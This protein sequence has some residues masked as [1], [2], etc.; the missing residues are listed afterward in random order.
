[1]LIEGEFYFTG[2]ITKTNNIIKK[3]GNAEIQIW[4]L[5]RGFGPKKLPLPKCGIN[6]RISIS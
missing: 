5:T 2:K 6:L 4:K 1:V 3:I